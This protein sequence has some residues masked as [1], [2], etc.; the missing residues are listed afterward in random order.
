MLRPVY[1]LLISEIPRALIHNVDKVETKRCFGVTVKI[2]I[3]KNQ[4][5][6]NLVMQRPQKG[7]VN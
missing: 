2:I 1:Q 6:E 3:S 7:F 4:R 5:S